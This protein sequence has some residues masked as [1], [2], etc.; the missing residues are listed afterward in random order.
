MSSPRDYRALQKEI[1]D[2][3]SQ[4]IIS[5]P[6]QAC[7]GRNLPYLQVGLSIMPV[8]CQTLTLDVSQGVIYEGLRLSLPATI[9]AMKEAPPEG[10]S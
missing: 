1:D 7:E 8:Y 3:I 2:G 4:G 10:N 9:L 5:N 6:V